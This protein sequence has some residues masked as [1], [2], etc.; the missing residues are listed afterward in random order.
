VAKA[1][2]ALGFRAHSG[3]AVMILA[4]GSARSIVVLK[5]REIDLIERGIPKQPYHAAEGLDLKRAAA[6]IH[7]SEATAL[8]L[9]R[10][11]VRSAIK[12]T[13]D[14]GLDLKG[15]GL[16]MASGRPQTTLAATLA[17]HA[18]IHSAEGELFR[19]AI[20]KACEYFDLPVTAEKESTLLERANKVL[21]Y[22]PLEIT[23]RITEAGFDLGPPWTQ[24]EKRSTLVAWLLLAKR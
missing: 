3:W 21:R 4:S 6:L 10:T 7:K 13:H 24:D 16:L 12:E 9:A 15:A 8:K 2:A 18:L 22:A 19:S 1:M 20:A 14:Q 23:K 5:R 11:A 17:S